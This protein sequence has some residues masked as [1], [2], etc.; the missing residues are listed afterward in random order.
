[1]GHIRSLI[2]SYLDFEA[3]QDVIILSRVGFPDAVKELYRRVE[4]VRPLEV[5]AGCE[6]AVSFY[7]AQLLQTFRTGRS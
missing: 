5:M 3:L 1:M 4:G 7:G 2:F 6:S